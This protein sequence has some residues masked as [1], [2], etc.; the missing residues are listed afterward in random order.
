MGGATFQQWRVILYCYCF[1]RRGDSLGGATRTDSMR[2]VVSSVSIAE[3]ILWGEQRCNSTY[4]KADTIVSIAEAILWGEQRCDVYPIC[5]C[6]EWFQSQ[7]RFFGGSNTYKKATLL[8]KLYVSI[9]EAILWGE[10]RDFT[11]GPRSGVSKFQSQRRFFG[12]SNLETREPRPISHQV[13]IAEAILW[14][15]QH[16]RWRSMLPG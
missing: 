11:P 9:A 5:R 7:R 15:E 4:D 13:S 10:Q 8:T 16:G 6:G 3:A 1:N 2:S 12:G 14:G